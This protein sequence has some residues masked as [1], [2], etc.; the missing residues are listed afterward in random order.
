MGMMKCEKHGWSGVASITKL[1]EKYLNEKI[2]GKDG[3]I[4]TYLNIDEAAFGLGLL[5]SEIPLP[6]TYI[7]ENELT[8]INEDALNS[9][10]SE[11]TPVCGKCIRENSSFEESNYKIA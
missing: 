8:A 7:E 2:E 5:K 3:I 6:G 9:I 1:A 4:L 11:L 10:L